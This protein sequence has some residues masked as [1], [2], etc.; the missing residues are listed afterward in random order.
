MGFSRRKSSSEITF[1]GI[2]KFKSEGIYTLSSV[3]PEEGSILPLPKYILSII[4]L[5]DFSPGSATPVK[6][7]YAF[8]SLKFKSENSFKFLGN[9]LPVCL[10]NSL[11]A[12]L[13]PGD[14]AATPIPSG[15]VIVGK[16]GFSAAKAAP[17]AFGK[18]VSGPTSGFIII[19]SNKISLF[20]ASLPKP[21]ISRS[22]KSARPKFNIR[23]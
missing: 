17:I 16:F 8:C 23:S 4:S 3:N 19:S 6:N 5:I 20:L 11:A 18:L 10:K 22:C 9:C 12:V 1:T 13:T 2:V 14:G 7:L 21:S 15:S